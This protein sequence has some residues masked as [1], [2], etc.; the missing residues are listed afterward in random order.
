MLI[1]QVCVPMSMFNSD[2]YIRLLISILSADARADFLRIQQQQVFLLQL[3]VDEH[4]IYL[5]VL[6]LILP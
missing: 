1:N 5:A 3:R 4:F 6:Y 2:E